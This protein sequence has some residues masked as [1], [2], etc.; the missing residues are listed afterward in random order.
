MPPVPRDADVGEMFGED[1]GVVDVDFRSRAEVEVEILE[2]AGQA[3]HGDGEATA[4]MG[5]RTVRGEN[6]GAD[7]QLNRAERCG[8]QDAPGRA[9][10]RNRSRCPDRTARAASPPAPGR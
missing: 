6:L 9:S 8:A 7:D 10:C 4:P 1:G 2:L 3:G 5:H